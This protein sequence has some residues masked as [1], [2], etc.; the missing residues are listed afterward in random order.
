[1]ASSEIQVINLSLESCNTACTEIGKCLY[2][3]KIVYFYLFPFLLT[4]YPKPCLSG[5]LGLEHGGCLGAPVPRCLTNILSL[6]AHGEETQIG[7]A[8][9]I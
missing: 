6:R 5:S 2:F 9:D 1:M 8:D 4:K 3:S 7:K